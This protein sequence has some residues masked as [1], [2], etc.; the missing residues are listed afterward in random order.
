MTNGFSTPEECFQYLF[1]VK[2]DLQWDDRLGCS[3][4]QASSMWFWFWIKVAL[5]ML[6]VSFPWIVLAEVPPTQR[7][8]VWLIAIGFTSVW[9]ILLVVWYMILRARSSSI[10]QTPAA[11]EY[12]N[13][14]DSFVS[15]R[16][17]WRVPRDANVTLVG[18]IVTDRVN[19][20]GSWTQHGYKLLY[21]VS[22]NRYFPIAVTNHV[23]STHGGDLVDIFTKE[24]GIQSGSNIIDMTGMI[25][26]RDRIE[27]LSRYP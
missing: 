5:S 16:H 4:S 6:A 13:A 8:P 11:L 2:R 17:G 23:P 7:R 25:S 3:N 27:T 10:A 24:H 15:T 21:L 12:D 20:A 19:V 14:I 9:I 1:C 26:D 22:R 18:A